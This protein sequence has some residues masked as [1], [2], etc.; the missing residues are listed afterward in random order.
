VCD[1]WR[2]NKDFDLVRLLTVVDKYQCPI[3]TKGGH[4]QFSS[5]VFIITTPYDIDTTPTPEFPNNPTL[6]KSLNEIPGLED[7]VCPTQAQDDLDDL[8]FDNANNYNSDEDE[9][10]ETDRGERRPHSS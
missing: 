10:V 3:Q 9:V 8:A 1:D 5:K 7:L 6:M 4:G 2:E